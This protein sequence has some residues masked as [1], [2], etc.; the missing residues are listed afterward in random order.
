MALTINEIQTLAEDFA[1]NSP[2]NLVKEMDNLQLW[3][4]SILFGV[5]SADDPIFTEYKKPEIV[6]PHYL[7]P[8]E[9]LPEAKSVISFFLHFSDRVRQS[10]YTKDY[11]SDEWLYG[12]VEG[13]YLNVALRS[14]I[15]EKLIA[16]GEKALAPSDDPRWKRI[17]YNSN[18][19][20]RH[21]AYAAGLGTFSI[22]RSLITKKGC[23]G[24]YGSIITS[25]QLEPTVR[26]YTDPFEY[27]NK[28][29]SCIARCPVNAVTMQGKE[30]QPCYH[31]VHEIVQ[32]QS[33]PRFGCGK[34][35]TNVPCEN[36][37]PAK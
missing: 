18:W 1:K 21:A 16:S 30:Q 2:L 9:W 10:N 24:R 5:A 7:S 28:C 31:M 20:E 11:P 36:G 25:A 19:S 14:L 35:Q 13:D 23:A 26:P 12:R 22:T 34:C 4:T 3:E 33:A 8:K 15:C 17:G 37:I 27:C 29:G 32:T 6:G